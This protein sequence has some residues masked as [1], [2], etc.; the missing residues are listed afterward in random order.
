VKTLAV[1]FA[2][3]ATARADDWDVRVDAE[4][5]VTA[6]A[7]AKVSLTIVSENGR[8]ISKDGPL[9]ITLASDTLT[10]PRKRYERKQAADP[11]ADA[12]RWDLTLTAPTAGDHA[13]AI[14]ARFWVC[15][16]RVCVPVHATRTVAVHAK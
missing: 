12:P 13:L 14:D 9:R 5:S 8:V 4:I 3:T 7:A 16:K 10:L 2:L 15:G 11:A 1:L 6:G